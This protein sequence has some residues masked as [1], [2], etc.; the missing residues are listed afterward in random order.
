MNTTS[1]TTTTNTSSTSTTAS[2][3]SRD[4][5]P[6]R[7][8]KHSHVVFEGMRMTKLTSEKLKRYRRATSSRTTRS[9]LIKGYDAWG[10]LLKLAQAIGIS[11]Y[12]LRTILDY[13]EITTPGQGR[14]STAK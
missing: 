10:S 2:S 14:P 5:K 1:T 9:S 11:T 13:Q 4:P 6:D 7:L 3:T 8:G 12:T